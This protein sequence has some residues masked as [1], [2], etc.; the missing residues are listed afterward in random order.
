MVAPDKMLEEMARASWER[1]HHAHQ[2]WY[3]ASDEVKGQYREDVRAVLKVL[4]DRTTVNGEGMTRAEY[5]AHTIL[6]IVEES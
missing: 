1:I 2:P 4:V 3:R 6:G 5:M